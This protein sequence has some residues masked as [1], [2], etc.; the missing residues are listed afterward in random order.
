MLWFTQDRFKPGGTGIFPHQDLV[1]FQR[2]SFFSFP[3][4]CLSNSNSFI[5]TFSFTY[6]ISSCLIVLS[7]QHP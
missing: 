7:A 2:V 4:P 6:D 3:L 5:F 1:R